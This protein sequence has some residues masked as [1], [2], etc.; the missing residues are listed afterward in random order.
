MTRLTDKTG[1]QIPIRKHEVTVVLVAHES[2]KQCTLYLTHGFFQRIIRFNP[3]SF[4]QMRCSLLRLPSIH[5]SSKFLN[6]YSICILPFDASFQQMNMWLAI[7]AS[8]TLER[9]SRL[10][11][12]VVMNIQKHMHQNEVAVISFTNR[13]HFVDRCKAPINRFC[14]TVNQFC[15]CGKGRLPHYAWENG[16]TTNAIRKYESSPLKCTERMIF[17]LNQGTRLKSAE[18]TE[19]MIFFLNQGTRFKSAECTERMIFF[20][21]PRYK[22]K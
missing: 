21:Q 7:E 3:W 11:L 6:D 17:F 9:T 4:Q 1:T 19:R 14:G 8:T 5:L 13:R 22:V 15:F 20:S 10:A 18:C 16:S 12:I 2:R